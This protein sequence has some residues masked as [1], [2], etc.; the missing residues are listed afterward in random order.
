MKTTLDILAQER[1]ENF[2]H[3]NGAHI[4]DTIDNTHN[5]ELTEVL[6]TKF[7]SRDDCV[8]QTDTKSTKV[9]GRTDI[10]MR[11]KKH[12]SGE[13]RLGFYDLLIDGTAQWAVVEFEDHVEEESSTEDTCLMDALKYQQKLNEQDIPSLLERSKNLN[14][15]CYHLH[16]RFDEPLSA[17]LIRDG[18]RDLGRK[19]F[20][21]FKNEIFPKGDN[22]IGNFVWLPLFGGME[23]VIKNKSGVARRGGGVPSGRTVFLDQTG[24]VEADQQ[25]ALSDWQATSAVRFAELMLPVIATG[26]VGSSTSLDGS[27]IESNKPGLEKME[28]NCPIV[29]RWVNDPSGWRYDHWLGLASNYIV[30]KGGWERF[31]ELSKR[32][33]ANFNQREIDRIHDEVLTF[34]GPQTYEKFQEQGLDFDLPENAPKAPAGWGSRFDPIASPIHE[35][36]GCY[37]KL[38]KEGV[39]YMLAPFTMEASELLML[40]DGDV[41]TCMVKHVSGQEWKDITIENTDWHTRGKFMKALKHSEATFHGSDLDTIDLCQHVVSNVQTR[42]QGT[43]TI[44]WVGD[45]WVIRDRNLTAAGLVN[46]MTITPYDRSSDSLHRRV[47]YR[48]LTDQEYGAL[49]QTYFNNILKTNLPEVMLPILGWFFA[50][51]LKPR[52]MD[53]VGSFPILFSYGTQGGGKTSLLELMLSLHGYDDPTVS[54]CTMKPFPMLKLLCSTNAVPVVLDEYK[55]YDMRDGQVMDLSRMIRKLYRGEIEDKGNADQSVTHYHLQA[56]VVLCGE[57]KLKEAA[58]LERVLIA[59]F[60]DAIKKDTT[61]QA[62]FQALKV[63]DLQGFMDRYIPFC[64]GADIEARWADA[65][66]ATKNALNSTVVAPRILNNLTTMTFGLTLM[67]DFAKTWGVDLSGKVDLAAAMTNQV[68]EITGNGKGQVKLAADQM[69]EQLAI[70]VE[71]D[72]A[73]KEVDFTFTKMKGKDSKKNFLAINLMSAAQTF[74]ANAFR[75]GYDGELLDESAYKKQLQTQD[76]V[77]EFDYQKRFKPYGAPKNGINKKCVVIDLELAEKR[78]LEIGGFHTANQECE[79]DIVVTPKK[80]NTSPCSVLENL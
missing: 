20:G 33:T 53:L 12:L 59:G 50:V 30:F 14:G 77:I 51:P 24:A 38:G 13:L 5:D 54:S 11:L 46:P 17:R 52:I 60:T 3:K 22:G 44:G 61:Y 45:I 65:E 79:D 1:P 63:L 58:V 49:V 41:L 15:R 55:P 25:A 80:E 19:L 69:L 72:M 8:G 73:K 16:I 2:A 10:L 62:A 43:R 35:Q 68:E 56:P 28:A 75:I 7:V 48:H 18:L 31:V 37:G 32:D 74:K 67:Q 6:L 27:G 9:A 78:G 71:K 39:F 70:L 34:Y 57:A 23:D 42:K 21:T 29:T 36:D 40:P 47:H 64:L 66:R 26:S 76:Y 4:E